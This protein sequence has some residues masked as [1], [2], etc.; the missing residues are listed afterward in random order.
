MGTE[1]NDNVPCAK[2]ADLG[3]GLSPQRAAPAALNASSIVFVLTFF[4][5]VLLNINASCT[6]LVP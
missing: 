4:S 3:C 2:D 1:S 6:Y 5:V